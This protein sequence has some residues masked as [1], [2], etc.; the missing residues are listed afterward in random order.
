MLLVLSLRGLRFKTINL[1]K[2]IFFSYAEKLFHISD[3]AA[4][5]QPH[6]QNSKEIGY[7]EVVFLLKQQQKH[8]ILF[9][10]NFQPP[11]IST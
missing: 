5:L 1:K 3:K 7:F 6:K 11:G 9:L 10:T 2:K 8:V 4:A